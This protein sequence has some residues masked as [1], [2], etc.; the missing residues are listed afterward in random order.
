MAW[1]LPPKRR[2][3]VIDNRG[4][5][6]RRPGYPGAFFEQG[7]AAQAPGQVQND[8]DAPGLPSGVSLI[9]STAGG[10]GVDRSGFNL[11]T[12]GVIRVIV[13]PTPPAVATVTP[14]NVQALPQLV[15][16]ENVIAWELISLVT[17][18]NSPVNGLDIPQI[19]FDD[20]PFSATAPG[21]IY[22]IEESNSGALGTGQVN[23]PI[24]FKQGSSRGFIMGSAHPPIGLLPTNNRILSGHHIRFRVNDVTVIPNNGW[25]LTGFIALVREWQA[26]R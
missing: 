7:E 11:D 16:P 5:V 23:L 10:T 8:G 17:I 22:F 9:P 20:G 25:S 6:P 1:R 18:F 14:N 4:I 12:G 3:P 19:S 26:P 13:G 21:N 24:C 15:V 2:I